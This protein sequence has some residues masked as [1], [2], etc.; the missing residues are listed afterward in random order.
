MEMKNKFEGRVLSL[1]WCAGDIVSI[2]FTLC[3]MTDMHQSIKHLVDAK[4]DDVQIRGG[5]SLVRTAHHCRASLTTLRVNSDQIT[6]FGLTKVY[7]KRKTPEDTR[8]SV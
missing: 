5:K 6:R 3:I 7:S 2:I 1:S 8:S 4:A